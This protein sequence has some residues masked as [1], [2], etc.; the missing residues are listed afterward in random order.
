VPTAVRGIVRSLIGKPLLTPWVSRGWFRKHRVP[1][2]TRPIGTGANALHEELRILATQWSLPSLLRYEDRNSM[3]HSIEA[4][5]PFCTREM[6]ELSLRLSPSDLF[7]RNGNTKAVLRRAVDGVVP[8]YVIERPKSGFD[9]DEVSI[10]N[11]L[12]GSQYFVDLL[13]DSEGCT[14]FDITGLRSAALKAAASQDSR[15]AIFRAISILEWARTFDVE[16]E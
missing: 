9:T 2:S 3:A 10:F 12:F 15:R 5:V 16:L 14:L 13:K 1:L 4:R 8:K 11:H 6:L 7:D